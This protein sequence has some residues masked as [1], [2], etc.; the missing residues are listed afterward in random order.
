MI[1][2]HIAAAVFGVS[3]A[4][5]LAVST[6]VFPY[7]QNMLLTGGLVSEGSQSAFSPAFE[8]SPVSF[9]RSALGWERSGASG[10]WR[11]RLADGSFLT[12]WRKFGSQWLCFDSE[13]YC[14]TGLVSV[15]GNLYD[16]D[17][18]GRMTTGWQKVDGK[19]YYFLPEEESEDGSL[20][21]SFEQPLFAAADFSWDK[22]CFRSQPSYGQAAVGWH[23]ISGKNF[24]FTSD[25]VQNQMAEL[26]MLSSAVDEACK[27]GGEVLSVSGGSLSRETMGRLLYDINEIRKNVD[28]IGFVL[29]DINSGAAIVYNPKEYIFSAS[30][31]KGPYVCALGAFYA[32]NLSKYSDLVQRTISVSDN[33]TYAQLYNLY[34]SQYMQRL[35]SNTG[36]SGDISETELYTEIRAKDLAKLWIGNLE[37]FR[38]GNKN[39]EWIMP[40]FRHSRFSFI[41][42]ALEWKYA[43]Y[44]KPGW[45]YANGTEINVY[46][47]AGIVMKGENPYILAVLSNAS[48][49]LDNLKLHQ[50][51]QDLD[52]AHSELV[53]IQQ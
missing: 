19:W 30:T 26:N 12:G 28:K 38:S 21:E 35:L 53:K 6:P 52:A 34:G 42:N 41:D 32:D 51:V 15:D 31:L 20:Q 37:F 10:R 49:Y 16:M 18:Y 47:D 8:R 3:L 36:V 7:T 13:G 17:A 43:V 2:K 5:P 29:V 39:V 4:V 50:L 24:F 11:F 27:E 46:N 25:G 48:L 22:H 1:L 9:E 33:D 23:T 44:S 45:Y 40:Y 14:L